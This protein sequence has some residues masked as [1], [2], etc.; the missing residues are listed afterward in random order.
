VIL[1][2]MTDEGGVKPIDADEVRATRAEVDHLRGGLDHFDVTLVI[3]GMPTGETIGTYE[4]SGVT[5][6][7]VTGWI[8]ELHDLAA[9]SP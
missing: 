5:W 8:P 4:E 3:Q 9:T 2:A 7:L 1:A 6:L